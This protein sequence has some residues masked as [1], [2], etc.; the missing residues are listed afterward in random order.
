MDSI[1]FPWRS[2]KTRVTL[3]TLAIFLASLWSLALYASHMLREDMQHLLGE[4]QTSTVSFIAESV[5]H[6]LDVRLQG[7]ERIAETVPAALMTDAEGLQAFLDKRVVLLVL[8]N[9]G[10]NITGPDGIVIADAPLSAG[11]MGVNYADRAG[12]IA[13]LQ[14]GKSSIGDPVM[15]KKLQAPIFVMTAPIRNAQGKVIGALAGMTN[16]GTPNFLDKIT[17][18]AYGKTGGYLLVAPQQRLVVTATDKSRIMEVLPGP[19]VNPF[20]DRHMQGTQGSAVGINSRGV[21]VLTSTKAIPATGWQMVAS[22][23]TAEAFAPLQDRG[24]RLLLATAFLTLLAGALTWWMLRRQLLP[25][26]DAARM[27]AHLPHTHQTLVPFV[28]TRQDEI[29]ELF[30]G[31]NRLLA[32]LGQR[33]KALQ[34]SEELFR[35][36]FENANV[37]MCIVTTQGQLLKVNRH[38]CA[39]FGYSRAEMEAM[40]VND[41][42]H[43]DDHT[44]SPAFIHQAGGGQIDHAE[45]EKKYIHR[46]GQLIVGGVSSSLVR[47]SEGAPLCFISHVV[48]ITERKRA[49]AELRIAAVAFES[50][51][52]MMITDAATKILKVN[53]AFTDITGYSAAEVIGQTPRMLSSGRHGP[54]FFRAVWDTIERT[55]GWQGEIWDRRKSGEHYPKWLTISSVKDDQGAV[56]HYVGSHYD[57]T[58]RKLTEEKLAKLAFFDALTQLPNRTLLLDRLKQAMTAGQRNN[59]CGAVLFID[60]DHFKTLNDTLGHDKGDML[61]KSV[62]LR[63]C[64]C[65]REGDTVARLGGDEFVIVLEGLSASPEDAATQ[66]RSVGEKILIALNLPYLLGDSAHHSSASLGATLF[67]G[68]EKSIDDLL[69]H[70]DLAM[71]KS[72]ETGRNALRFFDPAMQ[73]VVM[74]RASLEAGLRCAVEENQFL[75]HY[76]AQVVSGGHVTGAEVLVRWLHPVRG[77][78]SPGEFIPLA[79]ETGLILP[80]GQWV[81]HAACAQLALWARQPAL[82]H[83]TVAVNVSAHQFREPDFVAWVLK[84]LRD[85]G[86]RPERLKLELTESLLVDNVEDIIAKMVELKAWGVGFS[87]DD[88]GTGYSSLSYLKRLPLDQLKID[89]SFVRDVLIDTNDAAIATTIVALAR[90]LGLSVIAEG[91]E[92]AEQQDFLATSGCHAY[93]GY[94]FSKP[95]PVDKFEVFALHT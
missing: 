65:V 69:K 35:K 48:D 49:E 64:A 51:E 55:G 12:V 5:N 9:A 74:E 94:H 17:G 2:L 88:F 93:Q 62:A 95:V 38:M 4:Q 1:N 31:F 39:I 68:H 78:V 45:F 52:G 33:E 22:L 47:D 63:L 16:L 28:I 80:L 8:F 66:T 40:H 90:S 76:Q 89:Q 34:E 60:L 87:L 53:K 41:I 15:G 57:I 6:E 54:D 13:A 27:L 7:L 85:T 59:T 73:T 10:I 79:E 21:E 24:R 86:A 14:N 30:A 11:R 26:F 70:A 67:C 44:I 91:V 71:Y 75:L 56:T 84:V 3:F 32:T 25:I 61:L 58:D 37:G 36:G 42:A 20:V 43:P 50:Q 82:A 18:N 29:G 77:M 81:L 83:L 19:G 72:K 92:T 23:P 46:N